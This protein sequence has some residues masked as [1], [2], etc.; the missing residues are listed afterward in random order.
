MWRDRGVWVVDLH[1]LDAALTRRLAKAWLEAPPTEGAVVWVHGVGR[2]SGPRGPVLVHVVRE[3]LG[4][5]GQLRAVSPGRTAWIVDESA[6][7]W[8]K[9]EWGWATR[10]LFLL[11]AVLAAVGLWAAACGP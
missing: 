2:R 1:D 6:P 11:L 7:G 8:V 4:A 9:G 3:V 10:V 5:E